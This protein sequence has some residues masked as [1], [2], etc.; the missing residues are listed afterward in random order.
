[1][2]WFRYN[3]NHPYNQDI[4]CRRSYNT[5]VGWLASQKHNY[6]HRCS[7]NKYYRVGQKLQ[8][9]YCLLFWN[10]SRLS[11]RHPRYTPKDRCHSIRI[12][13]QTERTRRGMLLSPLLGRSPPCRLYRL[14]TTHLGSPG[15]GCRPRCRIPQDCRQARPGIHGTWCCTNTRKGKLRR[16]D[17]RCRF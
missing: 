10:T 6:C 12:A 1:M 4:W 8:D 16:S 17:S 3:N 7:C 2:W 5:K 9:S 15:N 14:G 13:P 11:R